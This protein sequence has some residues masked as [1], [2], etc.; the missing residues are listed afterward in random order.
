MADRIC[1]TETIESALGLNLTGATIT[2]KARGGPA[3]P[4][5]SAQD[6]GAQLVQPLVSVNGRIEDAGGQEA[7]APVGSYDGDI[8]YGADTAT[9]PW[10]ATKQ[11]GFATALPPGVGTSAP[12]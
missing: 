3:A 1:L 4:V 2:V 10:E 5:Y 9:Y 11:P 7:W 6:G 8:T 12:E